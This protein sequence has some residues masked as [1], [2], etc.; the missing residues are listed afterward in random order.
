MQS[1]LVT[2]HQNEKYSL[3]QKQDAE[4]PSKIIDMQ[5][6]QTHG[7]CHDKKTEQESLAGQPIAATDSSQRGLCHGKKSELESLVEQPIAATDS[8][9]YNLPAGLGVLG[10]RSARTINLPA[11]LGLHSANSSNLSADI[12]LGAA[13]W[14][15]NK[16]FKLI[17]A[18]SFKGAQFAPNFFQVGNFNSSKLIVMYSKISF[19]FCKDCRIFCEGVKEAIIDTINR[20]NMAFGHN[21]AF[22]SAFGHKMAFGPAFGHNAAFGLAFGHNR[23]LIMA[24]CHVK[25][26]KLC[27]LIVEYWKPI[28][29]NLLWRGSDDGVH[30]RQEGLAAAVQPNPV[31]D[32]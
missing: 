4:L 8:S 13:S 32:T 10:L 5:N 3:S 18:L 9:Q 17:N 28:Q 21:M 19:H 27:R 23:L 25:L 12:G 24:F 29:P 22:G 14:N 30:E 20:N 11:G 1:F 2:F 7:L 26:F 6:T 15:S 31:H 16:T